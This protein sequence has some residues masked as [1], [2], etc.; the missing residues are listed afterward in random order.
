GEKI[1]DALIQ[2]RLIPGGPILQGPAK[3]WWKGE[4]VGM[5]YCYIFTYTT[6]DKKEALIEEV[7]KNSIE[8]VPVITF[9]DIDANQ[10][11]LEWIDK[12]LGNRNEQI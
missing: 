6:S 8:E 4:I 12:T 11:L 1:R 7:K 3:F 10:E 2:K 9:T 5:D